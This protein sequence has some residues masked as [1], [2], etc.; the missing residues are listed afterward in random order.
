M[1]T[2]HVNKLINLGASLPQHL[3]N[4]NVTKRK[5]EQEV[6]VRNGSV[7]LF[8]SGTDGGG[9]MRIGEGTLWN[10]KQKNQFEILA[11]FEELAQSL[12]NEMMV[13]EPNELRANLNT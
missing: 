8:T 7:Q 4:N 12:N 11:R 2:G 9:H 10:Q 5:K 3:R 13:E 1:N 6:V